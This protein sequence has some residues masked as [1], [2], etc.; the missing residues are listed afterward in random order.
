MF[1]YSFPRLFLILTYNIKY[2]ECKNVQLVLNVEPV[3][4][5]RFQIAR[6]DAVNMDNYEPEVWEC[7]PVKGL[8]A[9]VQDHLVIL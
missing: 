2:F 1:R 7:L 3:V 9:I 8:T 6:Y 5:Q 4:C